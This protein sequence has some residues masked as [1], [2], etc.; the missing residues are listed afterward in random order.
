MACS[1]MNFIF[2]DNEFGSS[3]NCIDIYQLSMFDVLDNYVEV[4]VTSIWHLL[5]LY[6]SGLWFNVMFFQLLYDLNLLK[7]TLKRDYYL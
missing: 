3:S 6:P 2:D 4:Q 7:E 1:P 5:C